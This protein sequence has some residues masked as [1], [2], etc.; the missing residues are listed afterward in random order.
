MSETDETALPA[1]FLR[2]K[3]AGSIRSMIVPGGIERS[4]ITLTLFC[5]REGDA[6]RGTD[7]ISAH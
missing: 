1:D 7:E 4:R 2:W 6:A 5:L 3:S